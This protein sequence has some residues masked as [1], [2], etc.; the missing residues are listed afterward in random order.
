MEIKKEDIGTFR[1]VA[2]QMNKLMLEIQQYCPEAHWFI[3]NAGIIM[4]MQ[5]AQTASSMYMFDALAA[6]ER[7]DSMHQGECH[8]K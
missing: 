5:K 4:L 8:V 7:I 6:V 3:T 1:D 2:V